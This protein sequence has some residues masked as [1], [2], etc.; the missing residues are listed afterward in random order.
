MKHDRLATKRKTPGENKPNKKTDQPLACQIN[1]PL[2]SL[3]RAAKEIVKT[4]WRVVVFFLSVSNFR[5]TVDLIHRH[6]VYTLAL[7]RLAE[8]NSSKGTL[9]WRQPI[10]IERV[11]NES[12]RE[13]LLGS[14]EAREHVN[15]ERLI[16]N[17]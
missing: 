17:R 11:S 7:F 15:N 4:S 1:K 5:P 9:H 10:H 12:K 13:T 14:S 8:D 3:S 2:A 16:E 6:I